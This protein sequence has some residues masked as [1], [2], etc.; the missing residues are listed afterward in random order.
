MANAGLILAEAHVEGP[1]Q[2]ILDSPMLPH[3]LGDAGSAKGRQAAEIVA[4]FAGLAVR[5]RDGG[6]DLHDGLQSGPF[7]Q[8]AT[9]LRQRRE[10]VFA[11]FLAAPALLVG[12]D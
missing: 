3:A 4:D 12:D 1:V 8:A 5:V 6:D 11:P 7:L 2:P 10:V 9:L